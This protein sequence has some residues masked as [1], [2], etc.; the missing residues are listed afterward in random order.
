MSEE[1]ENNNEV[2]LALDGINKTVSGLGSA[3]DSNK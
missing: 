1:N 3:L 2:L